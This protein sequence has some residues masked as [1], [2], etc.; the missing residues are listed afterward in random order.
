VPVNIFT[1][2]LDVLRPAESRAEQPREISWDALSALSPT[3]SAVS[4][5]AA[6]G[7]ATVFACAQAIASAIASLPAYVY[8]LADRG[9]TVDAAHPLA[10]LI[11]NGPNAHQSWS[12]WL[13]FVVAQAVLRGNS[14]SQ[15]VRDN[16]GR[17]VSLI[18]HPWEHVSVQLL[19]S[20]RLAYDITPINY[21]TGGT[22][23]SIRLLEGEVFHLRDRSDDGLIG[24]SRL[25]RAG[26]AIGHGLS[27]QEFATSAFSNGVFPS[28][29]VESPEG[30]KFK[31]DEDRKRFRKAWREAYAGPSNSSRTLFLEWG[32]KFNPLSVTP[33]DRE[34][35]ASWRF[36]TE[37][38]AR[39]FQVP[40]PLVGIWDH[41]SFT[42]SETAGRWFAQHTLQPW[43]RKIESEFIRSVF[44]E[45]DRATRELEID[46]SGFARGDYAA[47][48]T[49]NK[50]AV[51]ARILTRNEVREAE[52]FNPIDGG[53]EFDAPAAPARQ[54]A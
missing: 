18:P 32:F 2:I 34:L 12:D 21:I 28:A 20:G 52:G 9:R 36:T 23:R 15:I 37:E 16:T 6:E 7:L 40:P 53:D 49:A 25:S 11:R 22:G 47:R 51:E 19:P 41:S 24:R 8:R 38:L 54:G 48:W 33:E 5:R 35:L 14:V 44:S 46:V 31:S 17:V 26:A 39:I 30:F 42:N 45:A 50:I 10:R 4:A 3:G 29:V 1:R 27:T 13:E 43:I